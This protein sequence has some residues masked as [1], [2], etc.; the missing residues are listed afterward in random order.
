MM[1]RDPV[2]NLFQRRSATIDRE[3]SPVKEKEVKIDSP[4]EQEKQS[5]PVEENDE[6]LIALELAIKRSL[7]DQQEPIIEVNNDIS[8]TIESA[9]D[10]DGKSNP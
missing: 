8:I 1:N 4:S 10:S 7:E 3:P 6:E 2:A 5:S 9:S